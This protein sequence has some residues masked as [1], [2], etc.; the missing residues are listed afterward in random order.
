MPDAA[1]AQTRRR[2]AVEQTTCCIVG[3]G[4][5]GAV[6]ALLLARTGV[7]VVLLEAF[8]D[9]AR[10]FRGDGLSPGTLEIMRQLGLA[11]RLLELPHVKVTR[12]AV[13]TP[14]RRFVVA[15]FGRLRWLTHYPYFTRLRQPRFLEFIV[16]QAARYPDFKLHMGARA[17][18]LVEEGGVVCGVRYRATDGWHEVRARLTVGADGRFSRIRKLAGAGF[19]PIS[20]ESSSDFL[21]FR[22]PRRPE[23]PPEVGSVFRVA[24]GGCSVS[25]FHG[26]QDWQVALSIPHGGYHDLRAA[27]L[28]ALRCML[29]ELIPEFADRLEGL[30]DWRAFSVL[31]V[32]PSRLRRW[33]RPGLLL[34]G[35]AA[36]VASPVGGMGIN[37]AIQ[38]A[39]VAANVLAG[40][41]RA[42]RLRAHDLASVQRQR[43]FPVRI[44]QTLQKILHS[45]GM[46]TGPTGAGSPP[47]LARL[48][49]VRDL[50]AWMI[51]LG[52][53]PVH[54]RVGTGA[55]ARRAWTQAVGFT[56]L[57]AHRY[58]RLTTFRKSGAP[59]P[60]A[61]WFAPAP[62][63]ENLYLMSLR[64]AGKLKRL[65]RN[66]RIEIAPAT[67]LGR[68]VGPAAAG[69]AR[70][71]STSEARLAARALSKKYGWQKKPFDLMVK[72]LGAERVYYAISPE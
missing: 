56:P 72:L 50:P 27:G 3:A 55:A 46:R 52:P 58:A 6:L 29:V 24:A 23:D 48:P 37:L 69:R 32:E 54:L 51:A 68:P 17:E 16:A 11:E 13:Q 14:R 66:P 39:V 70:F 4:P 21:W 31:A 30:K 36:H 5:A 53:W 25:V 63:Q 28:P 60:T 18:E 65:A 43:E 41:L 10:E 44:T 38:D 64:T 20:M 47:L 8:A 33:H 57:E 9:F 34:V 35:D 62:G 49:V 15:D 59:V 12:Y 19:E 2:T 22:L 71:L 61:V 40:P 45:I 42:G 7:P 1:P 67:A 26:D